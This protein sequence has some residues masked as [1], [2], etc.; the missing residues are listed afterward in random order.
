MGRGSRWKRQRPGRKKS[1]GVK[2][3]YSG[4]TGAPGTRGTGR[5]KGRQERG[6]GRREEDTD[7]I[8]G[9]HSGGGL[10]YLRVGVRHTRGLTWVVA[11][12]AARRD[13]DNY[14]EK[15]V[16]L[17]VFQFSLRWFTAKWIFDM[18]LV[19]CF[20]WLSITIQVIW[21]ANT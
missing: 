7:R 21:E 5:G 17:F 13:R 16:K 20:L 15:S 19:I 9:V 1:G 10:A 18:C 14:D 12:G 11:P 3:E 6:E 8:K 2:S 4:S